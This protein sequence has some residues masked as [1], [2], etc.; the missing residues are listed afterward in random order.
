LRH[1]ADV[2][3]QQFQT[4]LDFPG[5][6]AGGGVG[7]ILK[8]LFKTRFDSGIRFIMEYLRFEEQVATVDAVITG[9]GCLDLQTLQGKVVSG[10]AEVCR[11][12]RKPLYVV[13]G[14]NELTKSQ[15][16]AL[17]V[18]GVFTLSEAGEFGSHTMH[19]A[20]EAVKKCVCNHVSEIG[21]GVSS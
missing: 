5:A 17:G 3:N 20:Y 1:F 21:V 7:A 4:S 6:G 2:L 10:V 8:A 18:R 9:E 13:A 12:H 19:N 15:S 14:R 16:G 11:R